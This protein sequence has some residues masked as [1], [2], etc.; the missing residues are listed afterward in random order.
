[1]KRQSLDDT[2]I[3]VAFE[4]SKRADCLGR[5]HGAVIVRDKSIVST[6]YNG[7]PFGFPNCS[8][9]GCYRCMNREL[10]PSG[11]AFDICSCVH[12]EENAVS[13]AARY[14]QALLGCTVYVTG[15]P[16]MG[17]CKLLLQSG[18]VRIVHAIEVK[19]IVLADKTA[20]EYWRRL[21]G[22]F[23]VQPVDME[24]R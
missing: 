14:G 2:F 19:T 20:D 17:C 15:V 4:L 13:L 7:T 11:T 22:M 18:I 5:K 9:G 6:G 23:E 3:N 16:C 10:F 12:A 24:N 1:M 8:D 21:L